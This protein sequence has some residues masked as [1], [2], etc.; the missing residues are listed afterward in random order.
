MVGST[1]ASGHSGSGSSSA[2][3]CPTLPHTS[4]ISAAGSSR[5]GRPQLLGARRT[6][7]LAMRST[8]PAVQHKAKSL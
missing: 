2:A 1:C 4:A 6:R 5:G 8:V 3:A 7:Q